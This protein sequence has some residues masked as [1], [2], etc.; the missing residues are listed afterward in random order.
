[1]PGGTTTTK[2]TRVL[3]AGVSLLGVS[4]K[5]EPLALEPAHGHS[6]PE[7][8]R[9]RRTTTMPGGTTTKTTKRWLLRAGVSLRGVSVT[10]EPLQ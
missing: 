8:R 4:V 3:R 2:Q 1:M 6:P 5:C 7:A 10:G 9:K